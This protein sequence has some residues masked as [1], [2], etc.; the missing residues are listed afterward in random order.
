MGIG[1]VAS[2]SADR[3]A[4]Q[5]PTNR[6]HNADI[7]GEINHEAPGGSH[8][9]ALQPSQR[10]PSTHL[11]RPS[12]AHSATKHSGHSKINPLIVQSNR[13]SHVDG[14]RIS[15][16][17]AGRV[18]DL[19]NAGDSTKQANIFASI[20]GYKAPHPQMHGLH[21]TEQKRPVIKKDNILFSSAVASVPSFRS[22][23]PGPQAPQVPIMIVNGVARRPSE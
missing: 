11:S 17:D 7:A 5:V 8:S 14:L 22:K 6:F 19:N 16:L 3:R 9:S 13:S 2:A 1:L 20:D 10:N 18:N 21:G 23:Q 12:H 15:N 4:G